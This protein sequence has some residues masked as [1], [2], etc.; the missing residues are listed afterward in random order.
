MP[1]AGVFVTSQPVDQG[2]QRWLVNPLA[3]AVQSVTLDLTAFANYSDP[4]KIFTY[5]DD[6]TTDTYI[7]SGVPIK[8]NGGKYVPC[9]ESDTPDG[10]LDA[11]IP[12]TFTR[13]GLKSDLSTAPLRYVGVI[14]LNYL[15]VKITGKWNGFFINN[16]QDGT[17]PTII[18]NIGS[19]AASTPA[20]SGK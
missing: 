8:Y 5:L 12:V 11:R 18:S 4:S 7:K 20:A 10:V 2:D 17:G 16:P 6:E 14:N 1:N 3:D 13:K 9:K 15:P 19:G